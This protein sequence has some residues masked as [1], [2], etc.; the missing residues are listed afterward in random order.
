VQAACIA[1]GAVAVKLFLPFHHVCLP[2][3]SLDEPADALAALA[4]E[5]G[6]LRAGRD[7]RHNHAGARPKNDC[8]LVRS[9]AQQRRWVES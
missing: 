9:S 7:M 5:F 2:A 6:A 4:G 1:P 8:C 3:V